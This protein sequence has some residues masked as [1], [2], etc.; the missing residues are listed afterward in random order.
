MLI[1]YL[2]LQIFYGNGISR[3]VTMDSDFNKIRTA[4]DMDVIIPES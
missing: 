1:A 3:L 4:T 2:Y